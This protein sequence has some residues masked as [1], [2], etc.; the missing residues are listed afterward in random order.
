VQPA[1]EPRAL[2]DIMNASTRAG[3]PDSD[4]DDATIEALVAGWR[5]TI[6]DSPSSGQAAGGA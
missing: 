2:R 6:A 5:Q 3:I 4:V 1:A